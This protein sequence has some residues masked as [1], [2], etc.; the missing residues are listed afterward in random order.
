MDGAKIIKENSRKK[1]STLEEKGDRKRKRKLGC[2]LPGSSFYI[3]PIAT[4]KSLIV[5]PQKYS[6]DRST[7]ARRP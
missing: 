1:K 5:R 6:G 2:G 4:P 3:L 7:S